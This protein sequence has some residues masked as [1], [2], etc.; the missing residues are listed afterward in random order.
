MLLVVID[1][2]VIIGMCGDDIDVVL[3]GYGVDYV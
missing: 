1:L 2:V 3:V